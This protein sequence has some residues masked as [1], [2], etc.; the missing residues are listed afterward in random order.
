M[1]SRV[2]ARAP[3]RAGH[4]P[5]LFTMVRCSGCGLV[6][7]NPRP[8]SDQISGLYPANY[9]PHHDL[10]SPDD[11]PPMVRW[12]RKIERAAASRYYGEILGVGGDRGDGGHS[13][14]WVRV[15]MVL[16]LVVL[17]PIPSSSRERPR[18]LDI[19]CGTG[20]FLR[21]MRSE[22][23]DVEGVEQDHRAAERARDVVG[24]PV[25][26]AAFGPGM[27]A[28]GSFDLV[29]M[30]NVLEH[31]PGPLESLRE[32]ARL[33]KPGGWLVVQVPNLN[34]TE[35]RLTREMASQLDLPRHFYHFEERT[36]SAMVSTAGF[37]LVRV[38]YPIEPTSFYISLQRKLRP[39]RNPNME[40][41]DVW[42]QRLL[43]PICAILSWSRSGG[44]MAALAQSPIM[45]A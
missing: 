27:Y 20:R 6:F 2:E 21:R 22:G 35:V 23:W 28:R 36:L 8:R 38:V 30:W 40:C 12:S 19:G 32:I 15:A 34:S 13:W 16:Q 11:L 39:F 42:R 17:P 29:T 4:L 33:L 3:D 41:G 1:Q 18:L 45:A 14:L 37:R 44:Q 9:G 7:Q 31:L 5:G 24:V 25:V 43:W 26:D 10:R